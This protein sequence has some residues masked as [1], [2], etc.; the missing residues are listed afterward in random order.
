[1]RKEKLESKTITIGD[2][3]DIHQI[4]ETKEDI[5]AE[6][7]RFALK[8]K[9]LINRP[10]ELINVWRD[11]RMH[12][13]PYP[14]DSANIMKIL[15]TVTL[16][17]LVISFL[18]GI[19]TG[20]VLL[21]YNGN[22][23]INLLYFFAMIFIF[24]IITMGF[25]ISAMIL[26]NRSH[27]VM[28]H[29]SPAYWLEY[30]IA[31]LPSKHQESISKLKLNPLIGNWLIIHRSQFIALIFS[32]GL[33]L[34]LLISVI[35]SDI[36]FSWSTTLH[37][38][39][40]E[41][42]DFF[43][44]V[45]LPWREILPSAVPSLELIE[46]SHYFR[47][48]GKLDKDIIE[49]ASLL[50]EWWKFLAMSTLIYAIL[51]RGIFLFISLLGLQKALNNSALYISKDILQDM[52]EPFITTQSKT[53]DRPLVQKY[54]GNIDEVVKLKEKYPIAIG[55]ALDENTISEYNKKENILVDLIYEVGG[56][57]L[58]EEDSKVIEQAHGDI[59]FYIKS[60]EPPTMDFIDFI[61]NLSHKDV[62]NI[63]IYLIGIKECLYKCTDEDFKIW[64]RKLSLL[65]DK[66]IRIKR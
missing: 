1:M 28:V 13:I 8:H 59:I 31:Y 65:K 14:P 46:K 42:Y 62:K 30:L 58:L 61:E 5:S 41:L 19:F 39:S 24:P 33:F 4:L 32:I 25:T 2:Y 44:A 36:A 54:N 56:R 11:S 17:S 21:H 49:N 38:T 64:E 34:T 35:S 60:W 20:T 55:W 18:I 51:L 43:Y 50:G 29:L 37:I 63:E 48:G 6:N 57:K 10:L 9:I 7:R 22:Q 26:S 15:S 52:R 16:F 47:L 12:L 3:I 27:S 53:R 23:P 66:K 45:S 40:K